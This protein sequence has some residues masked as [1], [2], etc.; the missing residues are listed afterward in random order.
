MPSQNNEKNKDKI[1]K[2][3]F[4]LQLHVIVKGFNISSVTWHKWAYH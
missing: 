1:V 3:C 4:K 2:V